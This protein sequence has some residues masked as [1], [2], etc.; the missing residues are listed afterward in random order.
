LRCFGTWTFQLNYAWGGLDV[1]GY[2]AVN[3]AIHLAAACMLF[4]LARRTL[5]FPG[6]PSWLAEHSRW[7]SLSIALI[8]LVH[9]LQTQSVTYIV[10]RYESLMGL[11]Y[12]LVIYC[13]LRGAEATS[14]RVRAGAQRQYALGWYLAAFIACWAG[15]AT[16]EVMVTAPLVTLLFDRAYLA[17]SWRE[18]FR[19]RWVLYV[20]LLMPIGWLL[21]V[22]AEVL[23]VDTRDAGVGFGYKG[24]TAWEYLCSQPA[25]LLHY[26]RLTFWPDVLTLDYGWPVE[27]SRWRIYG[28]GAVIV[29]LVALSLWATIKHP[30]IG[31]LGLS[32]FLILAPTSSILPIADLIYEHRVYLPLVCIVA[33]T[34][35]GLAAIR[36]SL[37]GRTERPLWVATAAIV[38]LLGVRAVARNYE[39]REPIALWERMATQNPQHPRHFTILGKYYQDAGR[40]ADA[41]AA[42][43]RSIAL[44]ADD[45]YVWTEYGNLFFAERDFDRANELYRKAIAINP[46]SFRAH[47][48]IGRGELMRGNY[49]AALASS[50]HALACVPS[51]PVIVKQVAWLLAAAPEDKRRDGREALQL[52]E[53]IPQDPRHVD[54]QW[55]EV[56]AAALAEVGRFDDAIAASRRAVEAAQSIHSKRLPELQAQLAIYQAGKPWRLR[57]S[58]RP[59][60]DRP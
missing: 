30:R 36:A 23:V 33:V 20:A 54:I 29:G 48:N 10:Q 38:A 7:L 17:G 40:R 60:A 52:I 27:T 22:N 2:H 59:T 1:R 13:T 35:V 31:V 37:P 47:A 43:E 45:H 9:P 3:I 57:P 51:D 53:S 21:Y 19:R 24:L 58:T 44:K 12:L 18:V 42:F 5:R 11:C 55:Q 15:A 8:W 32:F 28:L 6:I 4:D 50:R 25:V 26:L 49:A 34:L 46:K 39:Y 41:L 14:L 16:K 56:H